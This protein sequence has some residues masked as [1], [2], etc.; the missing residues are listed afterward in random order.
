MKTINVHNT[1]EDFLS[2]T[3]GA[4]EKAWLMKEMKHDP[5]LSREIYLRRR[6][7]E[8]LAA[9]E[10]LD[11]RAKLGSVEIKKRSSSALRQTASKTAKYAAAIALVALISSVLYLV[12]RP[13]STT[14]ELYSSYYSGYVSPG[15]VRSG[16]SSGNTLMDNAL[17]LYSAKEYDKAIGYLEQVIASDQDNMEPLFMHGMANMEVSNFP[18]AEGSFSKVIAHNDNLYIEDAEWYLGLCYMMTGEN[19]KALKQFSA[20]AESKSR[21]SRQAAKLAG[22]LKK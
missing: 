18:V 4:A 19:N 15:A 21:H 11:L 8:I 13:A 1:I 22:K 10:V 3:A 2:G 17:A 6:T 9:R 7:D 20:I 5:A 12:L 16:V 14:D